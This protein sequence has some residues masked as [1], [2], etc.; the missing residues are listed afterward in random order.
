MSLPDLRDFA[1]ELGVVHDNIGSLK[2]QELIFN[3]LKAHTS[4][5]GIIHAYGSLEILPDG[6]GFLRSPQNS[7]LSRF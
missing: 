6:Y 5:N 2:K 7:Y 4:K 1:T 3:I